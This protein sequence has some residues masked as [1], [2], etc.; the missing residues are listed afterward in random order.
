MQL[1][2]GTTHRISYKGTFTTTP[3]STSHSTTSASTGFPQFL[4]PLLSILAT[5]QVSPA[6][7]AQQGHFTVFSEPHLLSASTI[8]SASAT[9]TATAPSGE[10]DPIDISPVPPPAAL[11]PTPEQQ[12][13]LDTPL[14]TPKPVHCHLT[15]QLSER[16]PSVCSSQPASPV[17]QQVVPLEIQPVVSMPESPSPSPMQYTSTF[18]IMPAIRSGQSTPEPQYA[19]M[20]SP[21]AQE[22]LHYGTPPPPSYSQATSLGNFAIKQP[23]VYTSCTLQQQQQPTE[24]PTL[25]FSQAE[26]LGQSLIP[27]HVSE[28]LTYTKTVE[29]V[30]TSALSWPGSSQ[31]T[32]PDFA[33]LNPSVAVSQPTSQLAQFPAGQQ[34]KTEPTELNLFNIV[35]VGQAP[36]SQAP[37]LATITDLQLVSAPYQGGA[38][39]M[40]LLPIKSRKYPNRPSKIPLH[41][42]PFPCPVEQCDRRFSRSDELT[43]HIRIHT[44]QKPFQ[45]RICMRSFSRS[46]HLTTHIRT[47][48]GEKPFQCDT[49]GRKFARSDEKKRHSKVHLKQK[50][51]KE[52]AKTVTTG[53]STSPPTTDI[54]SAS[55][56]QMGDMS[57]ISVSGSN[58]LNLPITVTTASL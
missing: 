9:A 37:G 47:H 56:A 32:M 3:P 34:I 45:C 41:E 2:L 27:I 23:P 10:T 15:S 21:E 43:R 48:T 7:L 40:K 24:M 42:R 17:H 11:T 38:G 19:Q 20:T 35:T 16:S 8:P 22:Q 52:A 28:G 31:Q 4:S 6:Q 58:T 55:V 5:G 50:M 39:P 18:S 53:A 44:G 36:I 30:D 13:H 29:T 46:D 51:K 33:A 14:S 54:I 12:H 49:C 25:D 57:T 26:Q 1:G